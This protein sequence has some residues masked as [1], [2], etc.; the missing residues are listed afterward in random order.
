MGLHKRKEIGALLDK[1][2]QGERC[3]VYLCFGERYLSRQAAEQLAGR[4]LAGGG[5][6]HN[7]SLIHI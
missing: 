5:S 7:L 6:V 4:L 1:I 2:D 3:Q